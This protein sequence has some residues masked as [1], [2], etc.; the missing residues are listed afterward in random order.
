MDIHSW[1][2]FDVE[3]GYEVRQVDAD[4]YEARHIDQPDRITRLTANQFEQWRRIGDNP[5]DLP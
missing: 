4:T 5:G 3:T 2:P 1:H